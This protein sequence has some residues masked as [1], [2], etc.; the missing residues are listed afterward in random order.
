[1]QH[2]QTATEATMS[3]T[4]RITLTPHLQEDQ[5]ALQRLAIEISARGYQANLHVPDGELPYLEVRNPRATMLAEKVYVQAGSF[6]W[7]WVES[8][9]PSDQVADAAAIVTRVLRT[10]DGD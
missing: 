5:A 1:V 3:S 4:S 7:P 2:Q 10:I 9:A 8:I 6:F